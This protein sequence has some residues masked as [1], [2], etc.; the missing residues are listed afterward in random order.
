[1]VES[2]C[3]PDTAQN[4]DQTGRIEEEIKLH[5]ASREVFTRIQ[6]EPLPENRAVGAWQ[7]QLF[8]TRYFDTSDHLLLQNQIALRLRSLGSSSC[9][10]G[11]K[12]FGSV[13]GGVAKRREWEQC[14]TQ[15]PES[16]YSGLHYSHLLAGPV[17]DQLRRMFASP[18]AE[19]DL[20]FQPLMETEIHRQTRVVEL[21][22]GSRV[23][24]ALDWGEIRA[25]GKACTVCEVEVERLAGPSSPMAAFAGELAQRY[26]L[27]ASSH[28]KFS[29]GLDLLGIALPKRTD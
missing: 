18:L 11:L 25:A 17:K 10:L 2:G 1:M 15:P 3:S 7:Q 29:L 26:G 14:L 28:S 6:K 24:I 23:E 9:Q 19:G 27:N 13:C 12:G 21:E 8:L 20:F 5:A 4:R 16:F 22:K